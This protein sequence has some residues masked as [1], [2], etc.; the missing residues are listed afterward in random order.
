[1]GPR[2]R[3]SIVSNASDLDLKTFFNPLEIVAR[4]DHWFVALSL[5]P[6]RNLKEFEPQ[7]WTIELI[8]VRALLRINRE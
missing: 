4:V 3:D 1:M 6:I 5:H 7:G 8:T 2:R